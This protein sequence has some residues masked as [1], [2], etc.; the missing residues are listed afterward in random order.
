MTEECLLASKCHDPK[1][2]DKMD[3]FHDISEYMLARDMHWL[4]DNIKLEQSKI[5][6]QGWI[7]SLCNNFDD[8]KILVNGV[9]AHELTLSASPDLGEYYPTLGRDRFRRFAATHPLHEVKLQE[10]G[11]LQ[12]SLVSALGETPRTYRTS[13]FYPAEFGE[14]TFPEPERIR[15]VIGSG[16]W[17][18][19][20]LGGITTIKRFDLY[21]KERFGKRIGEFERVLDWGCGA[22][23]LTRHLMLL[24]PNTRGAD[25]DKDNVAWCG[26]NIREHHFHHLNL[27]P[28]TPF[29]SD[30][31]DLITA[32]SV[33]TH[34]EE[35][36]QFLWLDELARIAKP[37]GI[38]LVSVR[39]FYALAFERHS[40]ATGH[41][42]CRH[43]F[44]T[45]GTNNDLR[46]YIE[47][48][49]YYKDVLHSPDYIFAKWSRYFEI[50]DI[51]PFLAVPQDVVVM[52]KR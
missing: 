45:L 46:G 14:A 15:R 8:L 23:R 25:I 19:Y 21:L 39:G 29:S 31:F 20:L 28:P 30:E 4:V 18:S 41:Q 34:L 6:L 2:L 42:L 1:D 32:G 24:N 50:I 27:N 13:W 33:F 5:C 26:A 47:D 11:V 38:L 7:I 44:V 43:H 17:E 22:A 49:T 37:G 10:D 9:P 48:D 3:I 52:R 16:S 12:F 51:I 40:P 35:T 36:D